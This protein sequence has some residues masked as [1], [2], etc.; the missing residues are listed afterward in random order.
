MGFVGM[1][2]ES[3]PSVR[4]RVAWGESR[5]VC[6]WEFGYGVELSFGLAR[7]EDAVL[8]EDTQWIDNVE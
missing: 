6:K 4:L 1:R 5:D 8:T 3:F 2:A 7:G